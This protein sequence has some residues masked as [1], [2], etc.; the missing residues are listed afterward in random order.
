MDFSN[1]LLTRYKIKLSDNETVNYE[2]FS[3]KTA[4]DVNLIKKLLLTYDKINKLEKISAEQ[5]N[6]FN[7]YIEDFYDNCK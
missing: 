1:F 5:L 6:I 2:T 7:N 4:V 3:E